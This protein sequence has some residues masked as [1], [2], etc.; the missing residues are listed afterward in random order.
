[1]IICT[2]EENEMVVKRKY[3]KKRNQD[4]RSKREKIKGI[5]MYK[6]RG[7]YEKEGYMKVNKFSF[8]NIITMVTWLISLVS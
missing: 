3:L 6:Q 4:D 7:R 1:M 5:S 2:E 8:R